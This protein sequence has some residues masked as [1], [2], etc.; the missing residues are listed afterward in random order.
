MDNLIHIHH[1]KMYLI[2][3]T[4]DFIHLVYTLFQIL[5]IMT[6]KVIGAET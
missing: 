4:V 1:L 5:N 2:V 6:G 3:N